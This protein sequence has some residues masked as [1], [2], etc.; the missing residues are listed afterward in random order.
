MTSPF[1]YLGD[2]SKHT[3]APVNEDALST[4]AVLDSSSA[5]YGGS[6]SCLL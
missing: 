5:G 1:I 2:M 6:G 3:H 4:G